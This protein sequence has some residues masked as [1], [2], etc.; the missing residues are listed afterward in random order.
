MSKNAR[1]VYFAQNSSTFFGN[2]PSLNLGKNLV[3]YYVYKS[4]FFK[5]ICNNISGGSKNG[6]FI[7]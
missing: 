6:K 3:Q 5:L 4:D 2:L 7:T 1:F